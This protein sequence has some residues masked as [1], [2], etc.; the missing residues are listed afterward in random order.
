MTGRHA[1]GRPPRGSGDGDGD[2]DGDGGWSG[3]GEGGPWWERLGPAGGSLRWPLGPP[4]AAAPVPEG[5]GPAARPGPDGG[6][7]DGCPVGAGPDDGPEGAGDGR[8]EGGERPVVTGYVVERRLGRGGSGEVWRARREGTAPGEGA[9]VALKVL[10]ASVAGDAAARRRLEQE[11]SL[12]ASLSD[13]H[14]VPLV[15]VVA[16]APPRAATVL[17]L[18]HAPG[19]SLA[20]LVARRG[21]LD[22]AEVVTVLVPL[23]GVLDRLHAGGVV[24][25]DVSPGN[26]LFAA[27]GRPLLGD[28]GTASLLSCG[29]PVPGR[30]DGSGRPVEHDDVHATAGYADPDR[31]AGGGP[32]AAGDVFALG[33]CAWHALTGVRPGSPEVR[34]PLVT[35]RPDLPLDLVDLLED[36][37][38]LDPARRPAAADLARRAWEAVEAEPV[39]LVGT[40]PLAPPDEVITH[41]VRAAARRSTPEPVTPARRRP[42]RPRAG[43]LLLGGAGVVALVVLA[44]VGGT[45][46]LPVVPTADRGG[47]VVAG[48]PALPSAPRTS[49]PGPAATPSSAATTQA[50][51]PAL[52]TKAPPDEVARTGPQEEVAQ[53]EAAQEEAAQEEET[54]RGDDPVAV[55]QAL[56]DV[57][58]LAF[59]TR[60][61]QV[62]RRAVEPGSA[63]MAAD[64]RSMAALAA[65]EGRLEGLQVEV[66]SATRVDPAEVVDGAALVDVRTRTSGHRLVGDDGEVL[67][68][69]PPTEDVQA[70]L[71]LVREAGAWR[72]ADVLPVP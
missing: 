49:S 43:T 13:E 14:V 16:T 22:A 21:A 60:D 59:A 64:E 53:E 57:R 18:E 58:A 38:E 62:L 34:P 32:T 12:L 31:A 36:C 20:A 23:A 3:R 30:E 63:A 19:G 45:A 68:Q 28:L 40:D 70:R 1:A 51:A 26:V 67:D 42:R 7:G 24:H 56:A 27:D 35:L 41:R 54:L 29:A 44:V 66:L 46:V 72:V 39:R 11:A 65:R 6:R 33:A 55:V 15:A 10:R 52:A 2:G 47:E 50:P 69:V 61:E 9:P 17:V 8:D 71:S 25:G 5:V 48:A 37:L 4:G